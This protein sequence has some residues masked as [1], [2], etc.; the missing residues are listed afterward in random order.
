MKKEPETIRC[1][2]C[3]REVKETDAKCPSCYS[4]LQAPEPK[5]EYISAFLALML[6]KLGGY[7]TIP[8]KN[9][10]K[11]PIKETPELSWDADK[12]AFTL[13]I[14]GKEPKSPIIHNSQILTPN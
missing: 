9:L 7:Q 11:F 6:S 8:L 3:E 2:K 12:Q 13:A 14:R 10:K 1:P 4:Y 5:D